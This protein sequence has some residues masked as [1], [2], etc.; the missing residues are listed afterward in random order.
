V[1]ELVIATNPDADTAPRLAAAEPA[2]T[3]GDMRAWAISRGLDV[4]HRGRLSTEVV[5]AYY[6][7]HGS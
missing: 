1:R 5:S 2:P 4:S 7:A 3:T 6:A